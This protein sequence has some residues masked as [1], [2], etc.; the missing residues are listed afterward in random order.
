MGSSLIY[1]FQYP[2]RGSVNKRHRRLEMLCVQKI[3]TPVASSKR[4][5][6]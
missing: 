6:E 5:S 2:G 4:L 3:T 1:G